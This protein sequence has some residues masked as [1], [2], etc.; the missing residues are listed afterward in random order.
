[1]S[2]RVSAKSTTASV[3][4]DAAGGPSSVPQELQ[5]AGKDLCPLFLF[6]NSY[7]E[8]QSSSCHPSLRLRKTSQNSQKLS[9]ISP[10]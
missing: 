1:M 5:E 2:K 4:V 9:K 3:A 10:S 6:E 8:L 7:H